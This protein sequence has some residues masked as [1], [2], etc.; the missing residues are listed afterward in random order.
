[1]APTD[2][3][4]RTFQL[5]TPGNIARLPGEERIPVRADNKPSGSELVDGY[6]VE[7][8]TLRG[9]SGSPVFIR[10]SLILSLNAQ[11]SDPFGTKDEKLDMLAY[12][13]QV[14]RARL[15]AGRLECAAR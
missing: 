1:M 8:Q 2:G 6:L 3:Q 11:R 13:E 4:E 7:A 10:P 15:M 9:L 14:K 5:F 12:H